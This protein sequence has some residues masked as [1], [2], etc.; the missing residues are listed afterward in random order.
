[1]PY[2]DPI[3]VNL[4][5]IEL[6]EAIEDDYRPRGEQDKIAISHLATNC[7]EYVR[8]AAEYLGEEKYL[9]LLDLRAKLEEVEGELITVGR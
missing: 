3:D 2:A 5:L 6:L 9:N 1:M 8:L 4:R 7:L